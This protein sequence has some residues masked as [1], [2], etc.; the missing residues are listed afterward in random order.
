[1]EGVANT[2]VGFTQTTA[3]KLFIHLYS[4]YVTITPSK[5]DAYKNATVKPYDHS[6]LITIFFKFKRD[7]K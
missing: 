4:S 2:N 1:M 3:L 5:F 6:K 7:Y